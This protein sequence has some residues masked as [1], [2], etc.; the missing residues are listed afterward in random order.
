MV[1]RRSLPAVAALALLGP[2]CGSSEP[3]KTP[4]AYRG[5]SIEIAEFE[6]NADGVDR[7]ASCPPPG[8]LGQ[9]WFP[10]VPDWSPPPGSKNDID[11]ADVRPNLTGQTATERAIE[12]THAAFRSC[13][14]RGLVHDPTQFGHVAIVLRVGPNGRV[15][16][17]ESYGACELQKE[18]VEC[19]RG[20]AK[21]LRFAPPP[22]GKDTI[23]I[24]VVFAPK[25]G[26][27]NGPS[28][29]DAYTAAA[30]V[31]LESLAP[32]LHECEKQAR[33]EGRDVEAFGTFDLTIDGRGYVTGA[34]IDP[35]GGDKDLLACA[36]QVM[37]KL[38]VPPPAGGK[39]KVLARVT[40]NPRAGTR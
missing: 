29:N 18:V 15:L 34:N 39:G 23:V 27:A 13:Y 40:F 28:A 19:M 7:F 16:Q 22:A 38:K 12:D 6:V 36:A 10:P 8:E 11:P 17:T 5:T 20:D 32:E 33:A 9:D 21:A 30:Y 4:P 3:P 1:S 35:W 14:H 25:N 24:P 31:A 37:Q 2:A 26:S